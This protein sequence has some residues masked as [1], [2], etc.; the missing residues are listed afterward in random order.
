MIYKALNESIIEDE[1]NIGNDLEAIENEIFNDE[2]DNIVEET[3]MVIYEMEY[4]SNVLLKNIGLMQLSEVVNGEDKKENIL[5]RAWKAIKKF[6]IDLWD[7]VKELWGKFLDKLGIRN[8]YY[9]SFL[10][11]CEEKEKEIDNADTKLLPAPEKIKIN[12]GY[13]KD[14]IGRLN[15]S[16]V[17]VYLQD[18]EINEDIEHLKRLIKMAK[19]GRSLKTDYEEDD[20][21][22]RIYY[23]KRVIDFKSGSE[24]EKEI[25]NLNITAI[26]KLLKD[27]ILSVK[28]NEI[29]I[30]LTNENIKKYKEAAKENLLA[31]DDFIKSLKKEIREANVC[32]E[33]IIKSFNEIEPELQSLNV[34]KNDQAHIIN[35]A[36]RLQWEMKSF[37]YL[38]SIALSTATSEFEAARFQS[39]K[40]LEHIFKYTYNEEKSTN[41]SFF[42]F[43]N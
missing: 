30:E 2:E 39:K 31:E 42:L 24:L 26:G 19:K 41:E 9:K 27:K 23:L 7:K 20:N 37:S 6:F 22:E 3:F 33:S 8:K 25:E 43:A 18:Q 14:Y 5:V 28:G 34:D 16:V 21:K 17:D 35:F 11:E 36:K 4:N 32:Y 29:E 12:E 13:F 10:K 1:D 40:L 38:S 15:S